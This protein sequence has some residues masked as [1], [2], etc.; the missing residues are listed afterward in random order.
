MLLI[1]HG[2]RRRGYWA[3]HVGANECVGRVKCAKQV[4]EIKIMHIHIYWWT[5]VC[6]WAMRCCCVCA[7]CICVYYILAAIMLTTTANYL[8]YF[9]ELMFGTSDAYPCLKL[10]KLPLSV[11]Q[12]SRCCSGSL[13]T[14]CGTDWI[15]CFIYHAACGRCHE[16]LKYFLRRLSFF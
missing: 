7:L 6:M 12:C 9:I 13:L 8:R 15:V 14:A 1:R 2:A 16:F 4:N 3:V 5:C 10:H 11:W